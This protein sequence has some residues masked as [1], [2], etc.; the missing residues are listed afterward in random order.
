MGRPDRENGQARGPVKDNRGVHRCDAQERI[1]VRDVLL[2]QCSSTS[3]DTAV[4]GF[5]NFLTKRMPM[6]PNPQVSCIVLNWNGWQNTLEC[7]DALKQCS[8]PEFAIIVV[9]N[10]STDDS[11]A[12]I[13]AAHPDIR[14]LETGKNLG[15]AGGNNVGIRYAL[16]HN[17]DYVWLLNNDTRPAPDALSALLAKALADKR[18]GAVASV[19]YYA[20]SPSRVE[21]WA[22][23]RINL[24]I[25]YG[26]NSTMPHT[27]D[28]FHSLNGASMLIA[29]PALEDA[30]LLDEGFF[31]YWEDTE[32]CLRLRKR[33]WRL[34]AAP[35]SRVLH[36]VNA[37]TG[38]NRIVLDRYQTASG[39]RLL[40]LHSPSPRLA[41]SLFLSIRF[42]RRLLRLQFARCRSV[43]L[44]IQ[45]YGRMA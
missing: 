5:R 1:S 43:W 41:S 24:W 18:I 34:A 14:M 6:A 30:G 7:L 2:S 3:A 16:A 4:P 23:A 36:K 31:L 25:G 42:A 15:F 21:A 35:E 40:R 45:D 28:W 33:G 19:T 39:L 27:D 11:I 22:G 38:G 20:D 17:S 32:F 12:R 10:G 8:Y 29:R 44:G 37:S 9:D 26:R 13:R